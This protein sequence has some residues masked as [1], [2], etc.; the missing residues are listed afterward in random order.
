MKRVSNIKDSIMMPPPKARPKSRSDTS[1]E[2]RRNLIETVTNIS[3]NSMLHDEFHK[4]FRE[5][6][7]LEVREI[8]EIRDNEQLSVSKSTSSVNLEKTSPH[9]TLFNCLRDNCKEMSN[10][11]CSFLNTSNKSISESKNKNSFNF[12]LINYNYNY[13]MLSDEDENTESS[14]EKLRMNLTEECNGVKSLNSISNK[15]N[16]MKLNIYKRYLKLPAPKDRKE[17]KVFVAN[18]LKYIN[19]HEFDSTLSI[20]KIKIQTRDNDY[21]NKGLKFEY[22]RDSLVKMQNELLSRVCMINEGDKKIENGNN[23]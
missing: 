22:Y 4:F 10:C 19:D 15:N 17:I 11:T 16:I 6:E 9:V 12:N 8:K 5:T 7:E 23:Y 3:E 2:L 20:L 21:K 14:V 18:I 1:E 13:T